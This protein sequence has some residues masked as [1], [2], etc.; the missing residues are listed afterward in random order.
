MFSSTKNKEAMKCY[1]GNVY[2][3]PLYEILENMFVNKSRGSW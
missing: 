2:M 3:I 1:G